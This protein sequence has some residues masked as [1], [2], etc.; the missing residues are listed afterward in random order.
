MLVYRSGCIADATSD[1][2]SVSTLDHATSENVD[3]WGPVTIPHSRCGRWQIGPLTL[4]I[5]RLAGE[6]RISR[7]AGVDAHDSRVAVDVPCDCAELLN[8]QEVSR[9]GVSGDNEVL[10]LMPALA[11]RD[12]VS[13]PQLPFYIPAGESVTVYVGHP[14]WARVLAG[15]NDVVLDEFAIHQPPDTWFGPD[16]QS[17]KLCYAARSFCQLRLD[18]V[19]N[20]PHR[21]ITSVLVKNRAST[22]LYLDRIKLPVPFLSI[23]SDPDS[24]SLW[25]EDVVLER[26]D[27]DDLAPLQVRKGSPAAVG[28]SLKIVEP[29]HATHG[30]VMVRAFGSLFSSRLEF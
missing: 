18:A 30:N 24:S 4:C 28:R 7:S 20:R 11:D 10:R 1:N 27:N 9:F 22:E 5:Q 19:Q 23:Y 2:P 25:T 17:G 15:K 8:E 16:T 6:W 12:V 14:L 3:W 29:R 21:A 26:F 13:S